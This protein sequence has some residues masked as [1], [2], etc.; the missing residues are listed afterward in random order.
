MMSTSPATIVDSPNARRR[1]LASIHMAAT[2]LGWDDSTYRDILFAVC[3][4]RSAG[5]LDFAGRKRFL[6]HLR[7]CGWTDFRSARQG[8]KKP[9]PGQSSSTASGKLLTPPQRRIWS[10]WQQLA[11]AGKVTQRGRVGLDAFVVRQT[12]VNSWLWLNDGQQTLVVES[13]KKWLG[14]CSK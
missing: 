3:S 12:G 11:D 5:E 6:A 8:P 10:L 2:A 1:D 14:R 13:L 4:V 7:Q 9:L